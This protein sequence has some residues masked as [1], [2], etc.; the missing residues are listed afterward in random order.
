MLAEFPQ[1]CPFGGYLTATGEVV[2]SGA[3]HA[4]RDPLKPQALHALLKKTFRRR[5]RVELWRGI[6]ILSVVNVVSAASGR[7][8][9]AIQVSLEH[10]DGYAVTLWLLHP[11]RGKVVRCTPIKERIGTPDIFKNTTRRG[12]APFRLAARV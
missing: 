12:R 4:A 9:P 10:R 11:K 8:G 2:L 3:D 1:F 7:K 6:A 5:A